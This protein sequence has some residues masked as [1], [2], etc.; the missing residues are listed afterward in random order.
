MQIQFVP[1]TVS[2]AVFQF[3]PPEIYPEVSDF[4]EKRCPRE[5]SKYQKFHY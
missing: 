5:S 2:C 4:Q 3:L 1:N